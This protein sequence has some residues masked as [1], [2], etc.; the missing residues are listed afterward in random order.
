MTNIRLQFMLH[1]K[2]MVSAISRVKTI[3]LLFLFHKSVRNSVIARVRNTVEPRFYNRRSNDIPDLT[4][5]I[6]EIL[7]PNIQHSV[8]T[9]NILSSFTTIPRFNDI[10]LLSPCHN[11]KSRFHCSRSQFQSNT[12]SFRRGSGFCPY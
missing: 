3:K 1:A 4:I 10:I 2:F 9:S 7:C 6:L 8:P 11:V 5:S 12:Y